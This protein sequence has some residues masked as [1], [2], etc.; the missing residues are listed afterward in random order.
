[1]SSILYY[2]N[3]CDKSKSLL[4]LL[5][6]SKVKEGIHYMCIDKRKKGPNN[7]W[8]IVLED[9]QEI[10]LPPHV[11]RVPALLLLNQ[12]H[13]VLYGDQILNHLRPVEVEVNNKATKFNGEPMP[14]STGSDFMGNFGVTSDNFSFLDQT[15]DELSAK[16]NGGMRQMYNYA[17]I[18]FNQT[19]ECP[20]DDYTP[21]K[22]GDVSLEKLQQERNS[23]IQNVQMQQQRDPNRR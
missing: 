2:S 1:M 18:D 9:G 14:F 17:T 13:M 12:N 22:I 15:P 11:N 8:Y 10:I 16:G 23:Q 3:Y 6:K 19:I 7:A 4:Q 5:S 20:K 21:N